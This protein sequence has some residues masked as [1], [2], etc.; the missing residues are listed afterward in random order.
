MLDLYDVPFYGL[1]RK[2]AETVVDG[3]GGIFGNGG[4]DGVRGNVYVGN[5]LEFPALELRQPLAEALVKG[6]MVVTPSA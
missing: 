4:R 3:E 6:P 1:L 5:V 2:F